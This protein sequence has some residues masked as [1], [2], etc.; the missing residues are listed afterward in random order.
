MKIKEPNY[1]AIVKQC[2]GVLAAHF[3]PNGIS[4]YEALR[5]LWIILDNRELVKQMKS[6]APIHED[7]LM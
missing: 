4:K 7:L 3:E 5:Q 6:T 2:Q 1:K